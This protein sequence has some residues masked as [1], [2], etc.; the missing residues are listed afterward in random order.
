[1]TD[2]PK[3]DADQQPDSSSDSRN[4]EARAAEGAEP[5]RPSERAEAMRTEAMNWW[6]DIVRAFIYLTRVYVP[7]DHLKDTNPIVTSMRA[8]PVIG[9]FVGAMGGLVYISATVLDLTPFISATLSTAFMITVCG[10]LHEVG[11]AASLATLSRSSSLEEKLKTLRTR[12]IDT[13]GVI[14]LVVVL[15]LKVGALTQIG[16]STGALSALGLLVAAG[17][18]SRAAMV[19][20]AYWLNPIEQQPEHLRPTERQVTDA[21]LVGFILATLSLLWSFSSVV[22]GSIGAALA[23]FWIGRM[24]LEK[25]GGQSDEVQGAIQIIS[26]VA[27]LLV[28]A[29]ILA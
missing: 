10:A 16:L 21:L 9:A 26:E 13:Y 23:A 24:A 20:A 15:L 19:G 7:P 29:A 11:F 2:K 6:D 4:H 5:N 18:L 8:F 1:M 22:A 28:A 14:A 27:F 3:P 25:L 17:T 12:V